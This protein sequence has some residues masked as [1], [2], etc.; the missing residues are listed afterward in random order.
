MNQIQKEL[1]ALGVSET[2]DLNNK[3]QEGVEAHVWARVGVLV[4]YP[5]TRMVLLFVVSRL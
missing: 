1:N 5:D 4:L 3:Q 2:Q